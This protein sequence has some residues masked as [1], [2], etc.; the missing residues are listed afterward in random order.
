MADVQTWL[1]QVL[2]NFEREF[3]EGEGVEF[4]IMPV[5]GP[6]L[7]PAE[8]DQLLALEEAIKVPLRT[9]LKVGQAR[10]ETPRWYAFVPFDDMMRVLAPIHFV[11]S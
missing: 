9:I 10:D 11:V 1:A 7:S 5:E 6:E 2:A 3:F 8:Q 4:K